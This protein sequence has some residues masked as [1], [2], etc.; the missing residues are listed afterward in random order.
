MT[1]GIG[2]LCSSKIRPHPTRP[3]GIIL[4][5]DTMGSTDTDSTPELHKLCVED[6]IYA[7]CAGKVEFASEIISVFKQE[8]AQIPSRTL[9]NVWEALNRAVHE[10]RMAHFKW[11]CLVPKY[12]FTP[13]AIF[14]SQHQNV[15]NDW[16]QYDSGTSLLISVFHHSG[17]ALLF[18]VGPVQGTDGWVH[19]CQYP[20]YWAIGSGAQNAVSWLNFRCQQLGLSPKQSIYHAYEARV[21]ANMAP[22]VNRD[23]EML[24]AFANRH[25]VL[26]AEKPEIE[27]C[28]IS[29]PELRSL[30]EKLGPQNTNELGHKIARVG[31]RGRA[32]REH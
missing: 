21:M 26:T 6:D 30:Y 9:G 5:A 29:L 20:G 8:L 17:I 28:P 25:Y 24:V 4:M 18:L 19:S 15:V 7:V 32:G 13:G 10:H 3:D 23:V 12:S 16:Q 27:G 11:D 22:T 31:S 14:E 1:I 2:V